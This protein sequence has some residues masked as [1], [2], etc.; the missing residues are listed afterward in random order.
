M[1]CFQTI[2]Q[3]KN[4]EDDNYNKKK[5]NKNACH[6]FSLKTA[7]EFMKKK[8]CSKTTHE[9]NIYFSINMNKLHDN[10]DMYFDEI[11]KYTDINKNEIYATTT[12]LIKNGEYSVDLIFP[13]SEQ[14]YS[15]IILKNAK[16]FVVNHYNNVYYLRDC[17][18][19]YQYDFLTKKE[20]INHLN[21]MYQ[22]TESIV[23][24]GYPIPEFSSIEYIIIKNKFNFYLDMEKEILNTKMKNTDFGIQIS[25][26]NFYEDTDYDNIKSEIKLVNKEK[27]LEN[28][29]T[30]TYFELNDN[31]NAKKIEVIIPPI[32]HNI[33]FD[34]DK[35][36]PIITKSCF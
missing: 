32:N 11:I 28:N 35:E 4:T 13:D 33:F 18:E 9:D 23:V 2:T 36:K 30:S 10:Q 27:Y 31:L 7:Y 34:D 5:Y 6:F 29:E 26:N 24:D 15:V 14:S 16:F 17:H 19:P 3:F 21:K 20:L 12:D 8:E 1:N 22:L 25:E